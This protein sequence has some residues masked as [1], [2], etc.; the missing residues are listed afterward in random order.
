MGGGETRGM[1]EIR[2]GGHIVVI[3]KRE[4]EEAGEYES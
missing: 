2:L 3:A 4:V 1:R